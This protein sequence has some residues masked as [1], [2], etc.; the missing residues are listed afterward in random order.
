MVVLRTNLVSFSI[1]LTCEK[2]VGCSYHREIEGFRAFQRFSVFRVR[3]LV[4]NGQVS[5]EKFSEPFR[6]S[7][8]PPQSCFRRCLRVHLELAFLLVESS[9]HEM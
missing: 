1:H 4:R 5:A 2:P 8:T 9:L 3:I 7:S 6:L